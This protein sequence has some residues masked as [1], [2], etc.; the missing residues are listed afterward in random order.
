MNFTRQTFEIIAVVITAI[1]KFIFLDILEWKFP[2]VFCACLFWLS[3]IIYQYRKDPLQFIEW[4]FRLDNFFK[5]FK[6]VLPFAILGFVCMTL[7][8]AFRGTINI[9]W[10]IIPIL[11]SYPI[12]GIIQQYLLMSLF[13]GNL[14]D[15][16]KP[17]FKRISIII[18]TA[19]LFAGIHF[20]YWWLILATFFLALFYV[21]IFLKERNILVLGLYHGWLGGLFYYTVMDIDPFL[22]TFGSFI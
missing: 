19:I 7:I 21:H 15:S 17:Q 4:G 14:N 18:I 9:T 8:G 5:V 6:L 20:P 10:H 16:E 2:F 12:W 11:I 3:Y 13:A 22:V 1:C